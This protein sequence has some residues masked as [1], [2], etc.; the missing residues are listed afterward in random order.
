MVSYVFTVPVVLVCG[1]VSSNQLNTL[2][3]TLKGLSQSSHML[4]FIENNLDSEWGLHVELVSSFPGKILIS[5]PLLQQKKRCLKL[6]RNM[7]GR[8]LCSKCTDS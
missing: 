5:R 3:H 7:Q 4:N 1:R 6:I 2:M 8:S